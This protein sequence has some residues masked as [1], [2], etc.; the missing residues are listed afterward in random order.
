MMIFSRIPCQS[1]G[2]P[3]ASAAPPNPPNNACDDDDGRP[4]HQVSRFH[5]MAPTSAEPTMS[6]PAAPFGGAMMPLPTVVATLVPINAPRRLK[7][8]AIPSAIRGV[9]ARVEIDVAIALAA[10]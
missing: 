9:R 10:S 1:T 7:T 4:S 6:R 8:A 2:A 3:P 5:E